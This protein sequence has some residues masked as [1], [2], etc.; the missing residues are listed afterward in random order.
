MALNSRETSGNWAIERWTNFG[1]TY[2]QLHW[3]LSVSQQLLDALIGE[4]FATNLSGVSRY[5]FC[6]PYYLVVSTFNIRSGW[7]AIGF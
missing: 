2:A 5:G 7:L 1:V 6:S 3:G 4:T